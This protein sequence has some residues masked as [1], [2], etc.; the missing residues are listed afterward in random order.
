MT[1]RRTILRWTAAFAATAAVGPWRAGTA[2]AGQLGKPT[3]DVVLTIDG[4]IGQANADGRADF[5]MAMLLAMPAAKISTTTQWTDGVTEFEGVLLKDV[6]AVVA[7]SGKSIKATA[8]NDYIA[9]LDVETLV[10][11]GAILAYRVNGADISVRDK[12]PLWIM[13][14]FDENPQL[15]AETI[16]SQSVWQLRKMTFLQ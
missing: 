2:N 7:A 1:S 9:D 4:A 11:S 8:L 6:F 12:G 5:D 14:P 15:K 13:F 16:Y 3:G 10:N